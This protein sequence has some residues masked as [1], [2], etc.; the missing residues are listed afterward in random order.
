MRRIMQVL[1]QRDA[2]TAPGSRVHSPL[3]QGNDLVHDEARLLPTAINGRFHEADFVVDYIILVVAE[4]FGEHDAFDAA[5]QV[6]EVEA[7]HAGI[8]GPAPLGIGQANLGD[9]PTHHHF[10]TC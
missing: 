6:F 3:I 2:K 9:H 1:F 8:A 4:S 10:R 7:G 5:G